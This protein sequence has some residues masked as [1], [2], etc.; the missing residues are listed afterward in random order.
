MKLCWWCC[1]SIPGDILHMPVEYKANVWTTRGQFCSW[2]CMK[3]YNCYSGSHKMGAIANLITLYRKKV[4]GSIQSIRCAPDKM[5]LEG[6]GGKLS[7][8]EFRKNTTDAWI[9]L[10]NEMHRIE[11]VSIRARKDDELVLKRDKPLKRDKNN[12]KNVLG[13]NQLKR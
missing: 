10:P 2:E 8:E 3:S 1:H 9:C 13:I 11:V 5:V 4:Y 7:I 6:F 12:I